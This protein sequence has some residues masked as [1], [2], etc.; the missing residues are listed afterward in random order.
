MKSYKKVKGFNLVEL[1]VSLAIMTV[2]MT[3]SAPYYLV[4][5]TNVKIKSV[6]ENVNL[7]MIQA[8]SEAIKRNEYI[9]FVLNSDT[10]WEIKTQNDNILSKKDA[11]ESSQGIVLEIN[12]ADSSVLTF[13]GMGS[14]STNTDASDSIASIL[15]KSQN[16]IVGAD[17]YTVKVGRGGASLVC[18]K[19]CES[20]NVN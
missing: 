2:L 9:F 5:L 19:D 16:V 17:S 20:R 11:K 15:V 12:P 14:V 10:S 18:S 3:F 6:A 7:G 4:W 1:M 13:N 8:R